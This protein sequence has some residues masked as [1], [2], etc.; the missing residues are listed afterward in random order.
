M[1]ID[2]PIVGPVRL[3]S[4]LGPD[5]A[6]RVRLEDIRA[7]LSDRI[8]AAKREG[9]L[10]EAE[11]RK[12]SLAGA[13]GKLAQ[14]DAALSRQAAAVRCRISRP[15]TNHLIDPERYSELSV[16]KTIPGGHCTFQPFAFSLD[17][18]HQLNPQAALRP[19]DL[20][21]G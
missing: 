19:G 20:D 14:V 11:G 2:N 7:N 17:V 5:P 21:P 9:W 18:G 3:C 12:L 4:L 6:Q 8:A 15:S 10:G 13:E 16:G 1:T